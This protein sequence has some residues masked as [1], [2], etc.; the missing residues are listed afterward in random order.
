L[1]LS[2]FIPASTEAQM[3]RQLFDEQATPAVPGIADPPRP[4]GLDTPLPG[5]LAMGVASAAALGG[6]GLGL[7]LALAL[8]PAV[9]VEPALANLLHAM[10]GIKALIFAGALALVLWRLRGP[11]A[12][13]A[14][15]GYS[16]G[17]AASAAALVW[18]WGLSGLLPGSAAFYGGLLL[19]YLSASRDPL[20]AQGLKAVVPARH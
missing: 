2:A 8:Q 1:S 12:V 14:L 5:P 11:V 10:V 13:P 15:A 17:L 16:T 7:G 4:A 20:L 19:V 6:L 18:L 9:A 3:A